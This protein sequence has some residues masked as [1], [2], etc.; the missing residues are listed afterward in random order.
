M[1]YDPAAR[2]LNQPL[3][4]A[5]VELCGDVRVS[6][7]GDEGSY[8]IKRIEGGKGY[9]AKY[10][11]GEV[12]EVDC[13]FC[14]DD[15]KRLRISHWAFRRIMRG[16]ARVYTDS[17]MM[18]MNEKCD[19]RDLKDYLREKLKDA[20][21]AIQS[22]ARERKREDAKSDFPWPLEG[23]V[24]VNSLDAHVACRDYLTGR[25]FDLDELYN[26]WGVMVAEFLTGFPGGPRI[27]YPVM[28]NGIR[29]WWQARLAYDPTR[30]QLRAGARKYWNPPGVRKSDYIYNKDGLFGKPVVVL[31]EGVTDVHAFGE[32]GCCLFGKVASI[33]QMQIIKCTPIGQALGVLILDADA[34]EEV[35]DF[36]AKYGGNKLFAKGLAVVRL[37]D[38]KDPGSMSREELWD[39]VENAASKVCST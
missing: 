11:S 19:L 24:P 4:D 16:S 33:R 21:T 14:E 2:P 27:I 15:R 36:I 37:K 39:E 28:V 34:A 6:A 1:S 17:L 22:R 23:V 5:L 18:C 13:P 29:A 8:E 12:Y 3:H 31:M 7:E 10:A 20:P 32:C 35:D 38:G 26:K 9:S 25:G 30:E